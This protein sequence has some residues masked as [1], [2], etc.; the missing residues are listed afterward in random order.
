[1]ENE[2]KQEGNLSNN[3]YNLMEQLVEENQSLWRIKN[4]YLEDAKSDSE[5]VEFWKYLQE[6]KQNHIKKLTELVAKK[7]QNQNQTEGS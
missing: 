2:P 7:L 6:D 3:T 4:S 5:T 1:M